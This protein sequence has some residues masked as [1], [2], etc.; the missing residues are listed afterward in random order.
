MPCR[1]VCALCLYSI[2]HVLQHSFKALNVH[3]LAS[4]NTHTYIRK[5]AG[6]L[7][8][9][10]SQAVRQA[11]T[12]LH[13]T[14]S[15]DAHQNVRRLCSK[16]FCC[17]CLLLLCYYGLRFWHGLCCAILTSTTAQHSIAPLLSISRMETCRVRMMV[18]ICDSVFFFLSFINRYK[19]IELRLAI[20]IRFTILPTN[21]IQCVR[22]IVI[23]WF[24]VFFFSL[25]LANA[26]ITIK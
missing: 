6:W 13:T 20:R 14:L 12:R 9:T 17:C 16:R 25:E 11:V 7:A 4:T 23:Y 26:I 8:H 15:I 10:G 18:L 1:A 19:K 24:S 3:K 2:V 22:S 5:L 21:A